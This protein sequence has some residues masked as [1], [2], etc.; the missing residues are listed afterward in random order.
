MMS[1]YIKRNWNFFFRALQNF[2]H[3][4]SF[5]H[6]S[7]FFIPFF[8]VVVV[9]FIFTPFYPLFS[10]TPVSF[11]YLRFIFL[12]FSTDTKCNRHNNVLASCL[13]TKYLRFFLAFWNFRTRMR[14]EGG[15]A[16]RKLSTPFARCEFR[17]MKGY[18]KCSWSNFAFT[19]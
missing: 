6:F 5:F 16:N 10:V 7:F 13:I 4:S 8:F 3:F 19:T 17:L 14:V 2:T 15:G 9:A 18:R 11:S 12:I 1:Y